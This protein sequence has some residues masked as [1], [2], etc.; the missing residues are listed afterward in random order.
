MINTRICKKGHR[1]YDLGTDK[2]TCPKCRKE[3]KE[4]WKWWQK[5]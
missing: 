5:K 2:D 1:L 3:E 4:E